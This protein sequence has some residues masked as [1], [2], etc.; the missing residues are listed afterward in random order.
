MLTDVV[1][2]AGSGQLVAP[3]PTVDPK[4]FTIAQRWG[5]STQPVRELK[6]FDVA[7][8]LETVLDRNGEWWTVSSDGSGRY[9]VSAD[10]FSLQ[11]LFFAAVRTRDGLDLFV[12]ASVSAVARAM[13]LMGAKAETD[14]SA[15]LPSL[16]AKR[17]FFDTM[18]DVATPLRGLAVTRPDQAILI[19]ADGYS[20][21]RRPTTAALQ[22][23]TYESLLHAGTDAAVAELQQ[24]FAQATT[25]KPVLNLSGGKDSRLVLAMVV[26]AGLADEIEIN[27]QDPRTA[28][29]QWKHDILDA[30]LALSSRLATRFDLRWQTSSSEREVWPDSLDS[31]LH[32]FQLF[33]G[34]RSHQFFPLSHS[35]RFIEPEIRVTGAGAGVLKSPW[36][37]GWERSGLWGKLGQRPDSFDSD[38]LKILRHELRGPRMPAEIEEQASNRF[39]MTM[40][41]MSGGLIDQA[42]MQH[43][44][45]FRNRGHVGGMQWSRDKGV[46]VS[47]PLLQPAFQRAALM[48]PSGLRD[49]GRVTSDLFEAIL[50][51]MNDLP[52]QSGDWPWDHGRPQILD[53]STYPADRDAYFRASD[54]KRKSSRPQFRWDASPDMS[55]LVGLG[56]QQLKEAVQ[57]AGLPGEE[58]ITPLQD[59]PARST[60]EQGRLLTRIA[61]WAQSLRDPGEFLGATDARS[62]RIFTVSPGF[63]YLSAPPIAGVD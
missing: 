7:A 54:T 22:G 19:S 21:V 2:F 36:R 32:D 6:E 63:R 1:R 17:D 52:F 42:A 47:N 38:T 24:T 14:W 37:Q 61:T 13:T 4:E 53:W 55:D 48:L 62:P 9:L 23:M 35:Y 49:A 18:W 16:A 29:P 40:W 43:Y 44:T 56:L 58:L 59:A 33:R 57:A 34:G 3:P 45:S 46:I 12:G 10:P 15:V 60:R 41:Q 50:P 28:K 31:Q 11:P 8:P 27:A 30:D 39:C 51:E 20:M 5:L 26:A 25:E